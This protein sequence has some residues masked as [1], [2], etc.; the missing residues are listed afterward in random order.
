MERKTKVKLGI[1]GM[2]V[3][4]LG[5]LVITIAFLAGNSGVASRDDEMNMPKE[6][7]YAT[8]VASNGMELHYLRTRPSNVKL[9]AVHNNVTA[10]PFYGINGGFFYQM[11]LLS[12]AVVNDVPVNDEQEQYGIGMANAKYARGTLVWDGSQ[13]R[14]SVQVVRQASELVVT[15]RSRFWAQGGISMSLDRNDLWLN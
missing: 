14:L 4:V 11:A 13:D 2:L 9:E 10:A 7:D 12:I 6:Y 8:A 1:A 5:V 3:V 15:D